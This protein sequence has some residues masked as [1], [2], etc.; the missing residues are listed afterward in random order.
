MGLSAEVVDITKYPLT[1]GLLCAIGVAVVPED[2]SNLV[3][4]FEIRIRIWVELRFIF[5]VR[6]HNIVISGIQQVICNKWK[7]ERLFFHVLNLDIIISGKLGHL[8]GLI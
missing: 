7:T 5:H 2:L 3:H 6:C 8:Y 4:A 1:I